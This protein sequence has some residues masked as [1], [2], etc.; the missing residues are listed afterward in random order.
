[1]SQAP[2]PGN[3]TQSSSAKVPER[4]GVDRATFENE[5]IPAN[6]PVLMR[7]LIDDWPVVRHGKTSPL[8]TCEYL[9][10]FYGGQ[11]VPLTLG[12][13]ASQR[14]LFYR[15]DMARLNFE[16]R[17]ESLVDCLR[18]MLSQ[19]D[20]T[21]APAI[22]VDAQP[23]PNCLPGFVDSH[24]LPLLDATVV[25]NIWI[26]N[27]VKV[28]THFDLARNIA[29]VAA[30]KRRFTLFPPEQLP[31]LY[32]GPIDFAPGGTPVSMVPLDN[33]DL[34]RFPRFRQALQTAQVAELE[35]GDALFIPYAWWHHV[36]SLEGFNVLINYWWNDTRPAS[37]PYD[38]L[39]HAVLALRDLPADQRS[40]WQGMFEYFVFET[41]GEALGHLAPQHRGHMAPASP[42]HTAAIKS[43][44]AQTFNGT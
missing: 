35:A 38:A 32:P 6:R 14:H 33:P 23:L 11:T 37:P 27:A 2:A 31:N 13:P 21:Q 42:Q 20:N 36:Q 25:P 26:G 1:M 30:G 39:L 29:C 15:N 17:P 8:A 10:Q 44:L 34:E 28:Q 19:V 4:R 22:Y 12:D 5:I 7:G 40:F 3:L 24:A 18:L 41:S 43:I 16:R 9:V